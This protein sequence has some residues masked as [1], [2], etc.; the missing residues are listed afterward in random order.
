VILVVW[1]CAFTVPGRAVPLAR[2]SRRQSFS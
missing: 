2:G 1:R